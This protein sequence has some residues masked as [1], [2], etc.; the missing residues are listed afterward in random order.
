MASTASR[1]MDKRLMVVVWWE[2][3]VCLEV[4]C[5]TRVKIQHEFY[6]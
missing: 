3:G 4:L 2:V 5:A 6:S 1:M